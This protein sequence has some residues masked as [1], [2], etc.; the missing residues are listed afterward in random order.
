MK[1]TL[2][3]TAAAVFLVVGFAPMSAQQAGQGSGTTPPVQVGVPNG[4]RGGG[5]P[6]GPG[7]A[8]RGRRGGPP[9]KP[10]P[11]TADGKIIL[12]GAT[13]T[14]KGLWLPA[15][16]ITTSFQTK[17]DEIPFQPWAKALYLDRQTH[18]LEPHARC[19]PSGAVRQMQTPYGV[20]FVEL[21]ELDRIY[22]F[23]VGGPHTYRTIYMDGR[24]HPA[25]LKPEYYGHSVGH[26]EGDT[27]VVDTVGY[28]E[29]FW[30]DRGGTPHTE[31]LHTIERFTRLNSATL[32][33]EVTVDDPYAYTKPWTGAFNMRWEDG[34][35]LFEYV[36]QEQNYAGTLMVGASATEGTVDRSSPFVP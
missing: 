24:S 15:G 29:D 18:R 36:C 10:A 17:V 1:R 4:G 30:M 6:G 33:Y 21:P 7:G 19:K 35:E 5:A 22:I 9:P 25:D 13:P 16:V 14:E 34:T 11:R 23:D 32:R 28:N 12:G 3:W 26:W 8:G 27:L 2:G 20:E 31:K